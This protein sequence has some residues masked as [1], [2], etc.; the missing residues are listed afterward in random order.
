MKTITFD[1]IYSI[2]DKLDREESENLHRHMLLNPSDK[3]RIR[4][5]ILVHSA[6][7]RVLSAMC[8]AIK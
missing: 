1:E 6:Y 2:I 7:C 4:D 5:S 8:E 3:Q